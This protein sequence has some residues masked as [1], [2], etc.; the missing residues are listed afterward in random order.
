MLISLF[1]FCFLAATIVPFSSEAYLIYCIDELPHQV[2]LILVLATL[3][4]WLGGVTSFYL[5]RL[6]KWHWLK[7]Y[8]GIKEEK[9]LAWQGKIEKQSFFWSLFTWLP[10][11]GDLISVAL[12]YFRTT[13]FKTLLGMLIGKGARYFILYKFFWIV[14]T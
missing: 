8:F 14:S 9:V 5:G 1:L 4:N 3:G 11:I 6:G 13:T 12:G 7:K 2:P 10:F